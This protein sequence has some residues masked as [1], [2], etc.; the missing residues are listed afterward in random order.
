MQ[1]R[2]AR[3]DAPE[4]STVA[5]DRHLPA[6]RDT[7]GIERGIIRGQTLIDIDQRRRDVALPRIAVHRRPLTRELGRRIGCKRRFAQVQSL[8]GRRDP[9]HDGGI[10]VWHV[11]AERD[12][13][14]VESPR[15]HLPQHIVRGFFL[16]RSAS[17][18]RLSGEC[19]R[20]H[21]RR[22]SVGDRLEPGFES[23]FSCRARGRES[24]NALGCKRSGAQAEQQGRRGT[25][26]GMTP[27]MS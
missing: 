16:R 27:V 15:C 9:F 25:R 11:H 18:V 26:H 20:E 1:F 3:L 19:P 23:L 24:R 8:A 10:V 14:R 2:F 13:L 5:D 6:H 4:G 12:A 7:E 17:D 21:P 22:G